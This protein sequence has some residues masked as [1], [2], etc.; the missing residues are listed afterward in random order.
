MNNL[1]F[2]DVQL[3]SSLNNKKYVIELDDI[4][5]KNNIYYFYFYKESLIHIN[6]GPTHFIY[7]NE[8]IYYSDYYANNII[9][10]IIYDN[11]SEDINNFNYLY[12]NKN[13]KFYYEENAIIY[14]VK[15]QSAGHEF[16][17][18][19]YTFLLLHV[20]KLDNY[21]LIISDKYLNFGTFMKSLL[22]F[23]INIENVIFVS[24]NS[25]V[26]I[27]NT[28]IF[29]QPT[30][31]HLNAV[32]FLLD[33]LNNN[34]INK[35]LIK[36]ATKICLIKTIN[37]NITMNS[38]NRSFSN[39]YN[40]FIESLGFEIIASENYTINDLYNI[41]KTSNVIILSWGCNSWINSSFIHDHHNVI[42]L[43]HE[44]YA[45]E[46]KN[47]KNILNIE[48]HISQWTSKCSKHNLIYDLKTEL[49]NETKNKIIEFTKF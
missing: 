38:I 2:K 17:G 15:T 23:F 37:N 4:I 29:K 3:L 25:I 16:A 14:Y 31:K 46:Y 32:N 20:H 40:I 36:P 30:N 41:I 35:N 47:F 34:T 28:L 11:N 27:K 49:S 18:I 10:D 6:G 44:G 48:S 7:D 43:C 26:N 39:D 24:E 42:T 13:Y 33:K 19:I 45:C 5:V 21:K 8:K 1:F 9:L 12:K 22:F